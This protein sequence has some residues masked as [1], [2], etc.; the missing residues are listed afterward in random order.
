[1]QKTVIGGI[2]AGNSVNDIAKFDQE[3]DRS[4]VR[5]GARLQ[6]NG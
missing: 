1:M 3:Y 5:S 2:A 6:G 4:T